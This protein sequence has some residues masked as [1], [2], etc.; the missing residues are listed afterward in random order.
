[1]KID[2]G[3]QKKSSAPT[4][5]QIYGVPANQLSLSAC[6]TLLKNSSEK[7]ERKLGPKWAL[8]SFMPW[9]PDRSQ[10]IALARRQEIDRL[11]ASL[12]KLRSK[13]PNKVSDLIF[14]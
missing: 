12:D 6:T 7:T 13:D 10:E 4:D 2:E 14:L 1:V 5:N 9:P 8:L 3:Q 11:Q